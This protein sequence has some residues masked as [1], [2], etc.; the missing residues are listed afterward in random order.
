MSIQFNFQDFLLLIRRVRRMNG[1][2]LESELAAVFNRYDTDRSG[3]L[4][5][6]EVSIL[7]GDVGLQPRTREEQDSIIALLRE[8]DEDGSNTFSLD[9]FKTLVSRIKER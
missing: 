3:E 2:I 1:D 4:D 7:L 9:E 8:A 5:M 6:R